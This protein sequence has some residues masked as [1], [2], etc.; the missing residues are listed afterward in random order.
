MPFPCR[1]HA[2]APMH[3]V[4]V[5]T[6]KA[7]LHMTAADPQVERKHVLGFGALSKHPRHHG[8]STPRTASAILIENSK[9]RSLLSKWMRDV[10]RTDVSSCMIPIR[11]S[12]VYCIS[13]PVGIHHIV[14]TASCLACIGFTRSKPQNLGWTCASTGKRYIKRRD[15]S[16]LGWC[17]VTADF[18]RLW[19]QGLQ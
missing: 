9:P 19:L 13:L 14:I 15:L 6:S 4:I 10:A 1:A 18:S 5:T 12:E 8:P 7:N 16:G 3:Y 2:K 11:E 17:V